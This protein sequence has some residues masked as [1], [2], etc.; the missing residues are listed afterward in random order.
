[1]ANNLHEEESMNSKLPEIKFWKDEAKGIVNP[2]LFSEVANKWAEQIKT[3]GKNNRDRNKSSQLRKFYD[4]VLLFHGR[5]KS[6]EEFQKMLPYIKILNAKAYYAEGRRLITKD[7]REFIQK[8]L[9][10][11]N[12]KKDFDVFVKF[13]EAFMGF[14]KYYDE[15]MKGGVQ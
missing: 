13:F 3:S 4:E 11:I 12:N 9:S 15:M 8:S 1:M 5:V 6:E 14:Y 10:Q 2:E 7:F